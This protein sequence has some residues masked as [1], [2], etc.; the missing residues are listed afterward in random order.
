MKGSRVKQ[1]AADHVGNRPFLL[2]LRQKATQKGRGASRTL[3]SQFLPLPLWFPLLCAF[4]IAKYH[5]ML[6][7]NFLHVFPTVCAT[8]GI[9]LADLSSPTSHRLPAPLLPLKCISMYW[10]KKHN[11]LWKIKFSSR[12]LLH[13]CTVN[14]S[15]Y[16]SLQVKGT[17]SRRICSKLL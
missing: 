16:C 8:L 14:C 1:C 6:Q 11:D 13:P 17:L 9:P 7:K 15:T 3:Y 12:S 2:N 10:K 4:T 5:K